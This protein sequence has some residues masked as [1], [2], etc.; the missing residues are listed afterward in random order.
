[1]SNSEVNQQCSQTP[2]VEL[3][4]EIPIG[5]RISWECQWAEDGSATGHAMC[6]VGELAHRAATQ[7][8]FLKVMVRT[9]EDQQSD[10]EVENGPCD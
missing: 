9:L 1:M 5:Q 2:L 3:L 10:E 6:P 7:I 4:R 8:D